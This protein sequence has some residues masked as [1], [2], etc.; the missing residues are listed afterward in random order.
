MHAEPLRSVW[1]RVKTAIRGVI[2]FRRIEK[3]L[4]QVVECSPFTAALHTAVIRA[5]R[6][7]DELI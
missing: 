2:F 6:K 1:Q 5:L 3:S 7:G 4:H